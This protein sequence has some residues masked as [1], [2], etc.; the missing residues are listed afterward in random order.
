MMTPKILHVVCSLQYRI[1]T[2]VCL[3]Y[4][5]SPIACLRYKISTRVCLQFKIST[6]VCLQ[7]KIGTIACLQYKIS[8]RVCLQYK[9]S[10]RVCLQYKIST[11]VMSRLHGTSEMY[12][13]VA[14][15]FWGEIK[16]LALEPI[17]YE[18]SMSNAI[19]SSTRRNRSDFCWHPGPVSWM[20]DAP[21]K[22]PDSSTHVQNEVC[23]CLC[24]SLYEV[25]IRLSTYLLEPYE[26]RSRG[27][28]DVVSLET[29]LCM[30]WAPAQRSPWSIISTYIQ[31]VAIN[32]YLAAQLSSS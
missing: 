22:T 6:R 5:I 4:K 26:Q 7:Y 17:S 13:R 21:N 31:T 15:R 12:K 10:T 16:I 3:Q 29:L 1:S 25:C 20:P 32:T 9:I 2:R 8:T 19:C 23:M 18:I 30:H 28:I 27:I 24:M 11:R 14:R